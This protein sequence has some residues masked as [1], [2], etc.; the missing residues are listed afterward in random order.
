MNLMRKYLSL[1]NISQSNKNILIKS[2][3]KVINSYSVNHRYNQ[4]LIQEMVSNSK[5]SGVITSRT[6]N[7]GSPYRVINFDDQSK[8]TDTVT[9]GSSAETKTIFV[10]KKKN[11]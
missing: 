2:I 8:L 7:K 4:V 3:Q 9:S 5:I 1:L 10:L 6:L 11:S